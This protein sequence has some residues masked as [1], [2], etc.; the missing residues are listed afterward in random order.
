MNRRCVMNWL[1][2]VYRNPTVAFNTHSDEQQIEFAHDAIVLLKEQEAVV[3]CKDCKN[4]EP[5]A[6]GYGIDC[7]GFWHDDD[8]FCADGKRKE[9][10]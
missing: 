5:G 1:M 7:D 6:C 2:E 9:G 3:R 8:W 10:R 4:G